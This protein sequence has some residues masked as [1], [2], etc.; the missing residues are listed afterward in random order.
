MSVCVF[1]SSLR[2]LC[3][4]QEHLK[5]L[6]NGW[7]AKVEGKVRAG[8]ATG[9]ERPPELSDFEKIIERLFCTKTLL[10]STLKVLT[11]KLIENMSLPF[12]SIDWNT[13]QYSKFA[14]S[15]PWPFWLQNSQ[16]TC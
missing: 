1:L 6:C 5:R 7:R 11:K 16:S 3:K 10:S 4:T 15:R 12:V 13:R 8:G 14:P 2:I 9:A